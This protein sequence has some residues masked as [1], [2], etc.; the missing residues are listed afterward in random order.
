MGF[1]WKFN[2]NWYFD[3]WDIEFLWLY[4]RLSNENSNEVQGFNSKSL[5]VQEKFLVK[6]C[7]ILFEAFSLKP[8]TFDRNW[9]EKAN[10]TSKFLEIHTN[11]TSIPHCA[12]EYKL[13]RKL[14]RIIQIKTYL[15]SNF[16]RTKKNNE[17]PFLLSIMR[18]KIQRNTTNFQQQ[19]NNTI[20]HVHLLSSSC[21]CVLVRIIF[22]FYL[23]IFKHSLWT[24]A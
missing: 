5:P 14:N 20:V 16:L 3:Q 23:F 2:G 22:F 19:S 21:F 10:C 18:V 8:H 24:Q 1:L 17:Q 15:K 13:L 12:F 9:M 11:L 6:K 7:H 4:H